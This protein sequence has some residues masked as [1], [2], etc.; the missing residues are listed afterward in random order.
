M[1]VISILLYTPWKGSEISFLFRSLHRLFNS[2]TGY[3]AGYQVIRP[4]GYPANEIGYPAGY[5]ILKKAGYPDIRPAG[6]PV[7]PYRGLGVIS[8]TKLV[9]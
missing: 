7:Q 2:L 5:R 6:Y 9:S 1:I 8:T 3:P 4:A